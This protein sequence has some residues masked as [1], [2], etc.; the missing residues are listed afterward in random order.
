MLNGYV[1]IWCSRHRFTVFVFIDFACK[2]V[3]PIVVAYRVCFGENTRFRVLRHTRKTLKLRSKYRTTKVCFQIYCA[4]KSSCFRIMFYT[5][6]WCARHSQGTRRSLLTFFPFSPSPN[7]RKLLPNFEIP[8]AVL[9][10]IK[11]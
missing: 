7:A 1:F 2:A 4:R 5:V 9:V 11:G 3:T 6:G 8:P 10:S